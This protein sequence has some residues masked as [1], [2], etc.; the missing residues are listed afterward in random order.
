MWSVGTVGCWHVRRWHAG[1]AAAQ[2]L[3]C[4]C[5]N[6]VGMGRGE[7]GLAAGTYGGGTLG[8]QRP[9]CCVAEV[10]MG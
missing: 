4:G 2:L 6:G 3:R 7:V 8:Q 10:G 1:P 5:R 9:S